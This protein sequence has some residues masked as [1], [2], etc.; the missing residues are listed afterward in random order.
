MRSPG[1]EEKGNVHHQRNVIDIGSNDPCVQDMRG[2]C[3]HA[4][5]GIATT[6]H[7]IPSQ[8]WDAGPE[9]GDHSDCRKSVKLTVVD[10][11]QNSAC[12][13]TALR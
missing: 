5:P 2:D 12:K 3:P 10:I 8:I 7:S 4:L 1:I 11:S 13:K 9:K 6:A